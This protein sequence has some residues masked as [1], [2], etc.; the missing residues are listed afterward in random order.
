[1]GVKS[2]GMGGDGTKIPSPCTPV[3]QTHIGPKKWNHVLDGAGVHTGA[4]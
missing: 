2:G 3:V 1:M 4:N